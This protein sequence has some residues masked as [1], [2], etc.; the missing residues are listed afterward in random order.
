MP[1]SATRRSTA[2]PTLPG[3]IRAAALSAG[4]TAAVL[5]LALGTAVRAETLSDAIALAY[6]TNPNLQASRAQLQAVDE[7][8]VTAHA[9]MRPTVTAQASGGYNKGPQSSVFGGN[10]QVESNVGRALIELSQ[11]IYT[12][13]RTAAAVQAAG[14]DIL[15]GREG[16]RQSEASVLE[17]VVNAYCDVLRDQELFA[18]QQQDVA[19]LVKEA[20]DSR[21]RFDAGEVTRT[22]VAQ[23]ATELAQS[24]TA[25]LV[26]QAQ[27]DLHRADYLA[28][29]GREPGSLQPLS[30]FP[31]LPKSIDEAFDTAEAQSA[32]L[33]QSELT[34]RA[35]R[36]RIVEA[37][38][39]G[40]PTLTLDADYG[41]VPEIAPAYTR[42]YDQSVTAT[43]TLTQPIFAGGVNASN[44]RKAIRLNANDR[45]GIEIARRTL[46]QSVSHA[47][48]AMTASAQS[49]PIDRSRVEASELYFDGTR[50]EYAI[51]QRSVLDIVIAEQALFNAKRSLAAD[52]HDAAVAEAALLVTLGRMEAR[53]LA[54]QTPI[55]DP[56][57]NL[58]KVEGV[59]RVPWEAP[60]I[61]LDGLGSGVSRA[62]DAPI[63]RHRAATASEQISSTEASVPVP[64]SSMER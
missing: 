48:L 36:A 61:A 50:Q 42:R 26:A 2:A 38:A 44:V 43:A 55:Y 52:R 62:L 10:V 27:L 16:L 24:R 14:D 17:T 8:Y 57:S 53:Y 11:P 18:I 12:G 33:L 20:D 40:K 39:A 1:S 4:L 41:F 28:A 7:G 19:L 5:T 45:I 21:A 9:G 63:A 51:G 3:S 64:S 49:V 23:I 47:W 22:D 35:S 46:I 58:R 15:A 30:P 59:G 25:L 29:V 31:G 34:E 60:L 54:P 32:S 13:G 56:A 37:R 6:E